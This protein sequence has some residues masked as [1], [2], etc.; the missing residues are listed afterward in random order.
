M[1]PSSSTFAMLLFTLFALALTSQMVHARPT[2]L[3]KVLAAQQTTTNINPLD[4]TIE[5]LVEL[6]ER[7]IER[8]AHISVRVNFDNQTA[9]TEEVA[10]GTDNTKNHHQVLTSL[11]GQLTCASCLII[12]E[13][14]DIAVRLNKT[15]DWIESQ[16]TAFCV[17]A[18][19]YGGFEDVCAGT[20]GEY[21]PEI[22]YIMTHKY[23]APLELCQLMKLCANKTD[24]S[25]DPTAGSSVQKQ[26][27]DV[28]LNPGKPSMVRHTFSRNA[29]DVGTFLHISD[30]HLDLLYQAGTN[31]AC[32]RPMCCR[33]ESGP[34]SNQSTTAQKWGDTRNCDTNSVML[35]N[36]VSTLAKLEPLP[37]FMVWTGD[38]PPHDI[39]E[40]SREENAQASLAVTQMLYNGLGYI[41]V[42]PTVGNHESFPVNQFRGPGY[43][44]WLYDSL[45]A[46]WTYWLTPE[47]AE[48]V[49]Y[50]GYYAMK[51][52]SDLWVIS[53]NTQLCMV[54]NFW[55]LLNNTDPGQQLQWLEQVLIS[56]QANGEKAYIIGHV[57]MGDGT[58][59][60]AYEVQLHSLLDQYRDVVV[61]QFVGHT[62]HDH[63]VVVRDVAT[64]SIPLSTVF[65]APS[66]TTYSG[67]FPSFRVY[68]YN[69]TTYEVLDYDQYRFN[70][71]EAN[72]NDN[73]VWFKAYSFVEEYNLN[74]TTPGDMQ[75][76]IAQ[77][78]QD[79]T[80]F[81]KFYNNYYAGFPQGS[82]D[83]TCEKTYLCEAASITDILLQQCLQG[84]ERVTRPAVCGDV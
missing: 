21:A 5:Q 49:K 8:E 13:L 70:L 59:Y 46:D 56:A 42:F 12:F 75:N 3:H 30:V 20:V 76:F 43:D 72:L 80:V 19:I 67:A 48:D 26:Q 63:F 66:V 41:P 60:V 34:P 44:D 54:G 2:P 64:N 18:K 27:P 11:K 4:L 47:A 71:T 83:S 65:I 17:K 10:E 77:M 69:R 14:F 25:V 33:N 32:P 50:A 23:T 82:C 1:S 7:N 31:A 22:L 37:D 9:T 62:H 52:T 35:Q 78:Q 39:W 79:P 57:P 15:E 68:Y 16:V 61:A 53:I 58:C 51:V 40:Q 55:L 38:N 6:A 74:G 84:T 29:P 36:M 81:D 73:P 28:L 45:S 24:A